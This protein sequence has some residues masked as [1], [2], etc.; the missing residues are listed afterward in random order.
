MDMPFV[1]LCST[2]LCFRFGHNGSK[3][4]GRCLAFLIG[5]RLLMSDGLPTGLSHHCPLETP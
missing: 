4:G 3:F 2:C 5:D 1:G